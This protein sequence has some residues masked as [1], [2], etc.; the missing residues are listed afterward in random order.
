MFVSIEILGIAV[1]TAFVAYTTWYLTSAKYNVPLTVNEAR[2]LWKIH[3]KNTKCDATRWREVRHHGKTVG[4]ECEC[5]FK[6][7]QKRNVVASSPA[8]IAMEIQTRSRP[9]RL[10]TRSKDFQKSS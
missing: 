2:I 4:F 6:H 7:V 5:G 8:T 3:R 1:W 9:K 10:P